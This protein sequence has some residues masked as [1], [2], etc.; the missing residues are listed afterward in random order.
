MRK[1]GSI[2]KFSDIVDQFYSKVEPLGLEVDFGFYH[3]NVDLN[4]LD[5]EIESGV[6]FKFYHKDLNIVEKSFNLDSVDALIRFMADSV[7]EL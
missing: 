2:K 7:P 1:R 5:D 6:K 4:D 3:I